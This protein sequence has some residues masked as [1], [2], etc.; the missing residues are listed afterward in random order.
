MD[1]I[2]SEKSAEVLSRKAHKYWTE[3]RGKRYL[4]WEEIDNDVFRD[5]VDVKDNTDAH[6]NSKDIKEDKT[7]ED[8]WTSL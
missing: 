4:E 7:T 2:Q 5:D 6:G 8:T 3:L 1:T